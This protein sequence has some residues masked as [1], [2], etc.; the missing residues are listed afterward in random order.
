MIAMERKADI[1]PQAL[2]GRIS[3]V[4]RE[5]IDNEED[6]SDDVQ[7]AINPSDLS[8]EIADPDD[9][10]PEFD[11]Y[12]MMDLVRMSASEPGHWDPDSD[13]ISDMAAEY[14]LTK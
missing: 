14:I 12:P 9:D 2:I 11:Y 6:Y 10:L 4:V 5:Y 7:L 13:A 3:D 8:L 1:D